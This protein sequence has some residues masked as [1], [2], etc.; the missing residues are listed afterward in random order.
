MT[1][2]V[3][4]K[5]HKKGKTMPSPI[6]LLSPPIGTTALADN[7]SPKTS[8]RADSTLI[9]GDGLREV[10]SR[11]S[12]FEVTLSKRNTRLTQ[13]EYDHEL[14]SPLSTDQLMNKFTKSKVRVKYYDIFPEDEN[15]KNDDFLYK[16]QFE[17]QGEIT[18]PDGTKAQVF[19]L[20]ANIKIQGNK[21]H[22][23]SVGCLFMV[24]KVGKKIIIQTITS[25]NFGTPK[26]TSF[27]IDHL[28]IKLEPK[29]KYIDVTAKTDITPAF[30]K[31]FHHIAD[32]MTDKAAGPL[33]GLLSA[34]I[35]DG[36]AADG[37]TEAITHILN[38]ELI[39]TAEEY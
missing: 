30:L 3:S 15:N 31:R 35:T 26:D 11:K 24:R 4:P 27:G 32:D 2:K 38:R 9:T 6:S 5:Q 21:E 25:P 10:E 16:S 34:V 33:G 28:V 20:K 39:G 8:R 17:H 22:R 13:G 36:T 19:T 18:L 14:A 23:L 7:N 29:G 12:N 37:I 1:V